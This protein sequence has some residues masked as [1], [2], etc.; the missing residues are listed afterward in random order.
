MCQLPCHIEIN[1]SE[2]EQ[3]VP[4]P[5]EEVTQKKKITQKK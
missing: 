5:E 3:T 2:E 1:L 4:K